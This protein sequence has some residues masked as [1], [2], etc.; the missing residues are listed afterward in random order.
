MKKEQKNELATLSPQ[1]S[2]PYIAQASDFE[3]TKDGSGPIFHGQR[4]AELLKQTQKLYGE[5]TGKQDRPTEASDAG[6]P[7]MPGSDEE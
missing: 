5:K 4:D 2:N 6:K 7:H 1:Q 3:I